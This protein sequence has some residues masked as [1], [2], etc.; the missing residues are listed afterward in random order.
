MTVTLARPA[1]KPAGAAAPATAGPTAA[2]PATAGPTAAAPATLARAAVL[3]VVITMSGSVLGLARDLLLARLFGATGDT[4]AFLVAWTVPET[5]FPLVVEGAMAFLMVPLFSRALSIVDAR[6]LVAATAP[7]VVAVL[8]AA[9]AA[10]AAGAPLLVHL[11][12]PGLADPALAVTC[13]RLTALTVLTFGLAGYISAALRARHVFGPPATIHLAYNA[14]ILALVWTLHGRL[15]IVAAAAGV[16]LGSLFMVLTQVPGF[17]RQIGLPRLRRGLVRGGYAGAVTLGAFAPIATYTLSR[18]AQVFVERY[19][20]SGLNPGTISHLNYA[21]KI[22]QMPMLVAL[23]VCTVTFPTL[24]RTVASGQTEAARRRLDSDLR[25]VIALI[26]VAAAYLVAL[27]PAIV[28]TLLE[29]GRFSAA[30]TGATAAVMR[31]YALGLLGQA[32]VGVLCR[33]FFTGARPSWY[34]AVAMLAGLATTTGLAIAAVPLFG[35]AA[36]AAAN[37]TGITV[38]AVLLL[39]GLHRCGV[40]VPIRAVGSA[41]VRL[42]LP[43]AGAGAA[44]WLTGTALAGTALA[45]TA[46]AGSAPAGLPSIV[47]AAAGGLVVLATF[48]ALAHVTR[49]TEIT[50]LTSRVLRRIHNGQ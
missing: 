45:S 35:A 29:H 18:Q 42:A 38:T 10:V 22:A 6:D 39:T 16:A 44:G 32:M 46:P 17:V 2:A 31:V 19:V 14:G 27:A 4:D 3:T 26:L 11:V 49:C 37:A 15:G 40:P 21:T 13:T 30:D 48:A 9:S 34:P 41:T 25:T 23:L 50:D 12:A 28:R 36:I 1:G 8:A 43:A 24:A 20:G 5:A 7:R 47:V 33:P